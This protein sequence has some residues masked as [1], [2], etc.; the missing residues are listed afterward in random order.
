M[1]PRGEEFSGLY[2][3]GFLF[4]AGVFGAKGELI[5]W[6]GVRCGENIRKLGVWVPEGLGRLYVSNFEGQ[7]EIISSKPGSAAGPNSF[8]G[9]E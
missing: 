7:V 9:T 5:I 6:V 3:S 1:G 2:R 4:A 8:E